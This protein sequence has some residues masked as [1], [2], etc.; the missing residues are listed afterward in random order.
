M[1]RTKMVNGIVTEMGTEA[2]SKVGTKVVVEVGMQG[3]R[4]R[5]WSLRRRLR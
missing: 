2:R 4:S 3:G 1:R 5:G